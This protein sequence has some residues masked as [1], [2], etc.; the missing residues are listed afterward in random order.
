MAQIC[1]G[2]P[3]YDPT[4]IPIKLNPIAAYI[5]GQPYMYTVG[6]AIKKT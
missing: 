4:C 3:A 2:G 6:R 5:L 1:H